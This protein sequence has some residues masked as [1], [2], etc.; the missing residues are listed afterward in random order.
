M[1][2]FVGR[3]SVERERVVGVLRALLMEHIIL[4]VVPVGERC[5]VRASLLDRLCGT[6]DR[7]V[8]LRNRL[9][10]LA[11]EPLLVRGLEVHR[12]RVNNLCLLLHVEGLLVVLDLSAGELVVEVLTIV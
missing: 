9:T 11:T 5:M 4:A 12:V 8:F 1:I 2:L 10:L 3:A 7:N 6:S